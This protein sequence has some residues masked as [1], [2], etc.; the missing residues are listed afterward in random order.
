VT[1]TGLFPLWLAR[2]LRVYRRWEVELRQRGLGDEVTGL[3]LR[4]GTRVAVLDLF[5]N[6]FYVETPA[7]KAV[8]PFGALRPSLRRR[9]GA[10]AVV[11][12][13]EVSHAPRN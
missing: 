1:A 9:R 12:A 4:A 10:R 13:G 2:D 7:G 8:L 5:T 6:G 3:K 11:A